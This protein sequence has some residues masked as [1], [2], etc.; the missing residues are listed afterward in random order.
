METWPWDLA[1]F[2]FGVMADIT[3][4]IVFIFGACLKQ[5]SSAGGGMMGRWAILGGRQDE[6]IL[7]PPYMANHHYKM[8]GYNGSRTRNLRRSLKGYWRI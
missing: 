7:Y 3:N 8:L 1:L 2:P 5:R 6:K 4:F